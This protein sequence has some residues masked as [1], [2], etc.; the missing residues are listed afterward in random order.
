MKVF[1]L[2]IL[3]VWFQDTNV[4]EIGKASMQYENGLYPPTHSL[5]ITSPIVLHYCHPLCNTHAQHMQMSPQPLLHFFS[6]CWKCYQI[7]PMFLAGG[8]MHLQ[9][10]LLLKS[11][12]QTIQ[13]EMLVEE[14]VYNESMINI[15]IGKVSVAS[16][17]PMVEFGGGIFWTAVCG[18]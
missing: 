7:L 15:I 2:M 16:N 11:S 1:L 8:G 9:K 14:S 17:L 4:S 13:R 5:I 6:V 10:I 18:M 3:P 12:L